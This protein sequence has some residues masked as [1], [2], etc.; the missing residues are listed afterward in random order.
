MLRETSRDQGRPS[1]DFVSE[2]KSRMNWKLKLWKKSS[3]ASFLVHLECKPSLPGAPMV[4]LWAWT[5]LLNRLVSHHLQ[6]P[7]K[8]SMVLILADFC[9]VDATHIRAIIQ[10]PLQAHHRFVR[11]GT[12]PSLGPIPTLPKVSPLITLASTLL[13]QGRLRATSH[14]RASQP[15]RYTLLALQTVKFTTRAALEIS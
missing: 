10:H 11:S 14:P 3:Q 4:V 6:Q 5:C 2:M 15:R 9:D 7:R 8:R 1:L 12:H 13:V